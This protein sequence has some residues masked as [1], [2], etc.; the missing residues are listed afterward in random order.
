LIPQNF[1]LLLDSISFDMINSRKLTDLHPKLATMAMLHIAECKEL[2][3]D[4]LVTSTYRDKESQAA[5]Y[6][7]GRT[8]PGKIVTK[9][10]PGQSIHNY[11]LAYDVV[12][13]RN[14][15]PVWDAKDPIWQIVGKAGEVC[16]LEWGG[17]CT[18]FK[19]LPHFQ[20]TGGLTLAD[21]QK[22][23]MI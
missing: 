8:A 14:G 12:P 11:R 17:R 19:D 13:M 1:G 7:Q 22:V 2:G 6:A 4:L 21:L 18:K 5:L 20:Y 15:K 9:A 16:G 23:V 10:G 3:I